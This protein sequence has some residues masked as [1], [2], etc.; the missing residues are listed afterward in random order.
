MG[1]LIQKQA[2]K[3]QNL[4]FLSMKI[5]KQTKRAGNIF[6]CI[7]SYFKILLIH[8]AGKMYSPTR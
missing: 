2:V 6:L 7:S 8:A 1:R 5:K 4:N 3:S